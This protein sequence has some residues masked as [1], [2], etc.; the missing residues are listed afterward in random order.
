MGMNKEVLF[1]IAQD[2]SYNTVDWTTRLEG[3]RNK[4][5]RQYYDEAFLD[6]YIERVRSESSPFSFNWYPHNAPGQWMSQ[7]IDH[8][9]RVITEPIDTTIANNAASLSI[10]AFTDSLIH[11]LQLRYSHS[12]IHLQ[13]VSLRG[14][15]NR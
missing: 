6:Q 8:T 3:L 11:F 12:T 9:S 13:S 14:C 4:G 2:N 7:N 10:I 5:L 15:V 1:T